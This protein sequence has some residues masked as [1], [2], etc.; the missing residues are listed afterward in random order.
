MFVLENGAIL[1]KMVSFYGTVYKSSRYDLI[2][3]LPACE[4][5]AEREKD[6]LLFLRPGKPEKA[7]NLIIN[8]LWIV[9]YVEWHQLTKFT[10]KLL[11]IV[12][13]ILADY[14]STFASSQPIRLPL[15]ESKFTPTM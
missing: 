10:F 2:I 13:W 12:C 9:F 6:M 11:K 14:F 8:S 15:T 5:G 4:S 3:P 7:N 1:W